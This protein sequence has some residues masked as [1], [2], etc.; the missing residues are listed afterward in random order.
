MIDLTDR[1]ATIRSDLRDVQNRFASLMGEVW[2]LPGGEM[3]WQ[4]VDAYPGIR[5]DRDMGAR[6]DA[7]GWMAEVAEFLES[8]EG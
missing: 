2:E 1:L 4:R 7:D 6:Q 5:L 3:V 8:L